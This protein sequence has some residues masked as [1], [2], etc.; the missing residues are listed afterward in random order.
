LVFVALVA[1]FTAACF[2]FPWR[3]RALLPV[4]RV[5]GVDNTHSADGLGF[6]VSFLLVAG[7]IALAVVALLEAQGLATPS[8]ER[9]PAFGAGM[10][11]AVLAWSVFRWVNPVG[12]GTEARFGAPLTAVASLGLLTIALSLRRQRPVEEP[13]R[14][15]QT[16]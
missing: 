2:L 4:E 11:V 1:G 6:D 3:E 10:G 14:R 13:A 16:L 8:P 9:V 12:T 7:L 5:V 15:G